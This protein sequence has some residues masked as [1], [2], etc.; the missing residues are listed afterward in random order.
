MALQ[1][2]ACVLQ[3]GPSIQSICPFTTV[4]LSE[5]GQRQVPGPAFVPFH[6]PQNSCDP[7]LLCCT[8]RVAAAW[9]R[10]RAAEAEESKPSVHASWPGLTWFTKSELVFVLYIGHK[11]LKSRWRFYPKPTPLASRLREPSGHCIP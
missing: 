2:E 6:K 10:A 8:L 1:E 9:L 11:H 4:P 3:T 5:A 7:D